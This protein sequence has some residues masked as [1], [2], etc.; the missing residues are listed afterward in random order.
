MWQKPDDGTFDNLQSRV[1]KF[2]QYQDVNDKVLAA[3]TEAFEHALKANNVILSQPERDILFKKA[4][5]QLL[6]KLLSDQK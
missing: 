5:T 1:I 3:M 6:N 2:M 4:V